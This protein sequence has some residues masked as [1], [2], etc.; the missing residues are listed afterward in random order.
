MDSISNEAPLDPATARARLDAMRPLIQSLNDTVVLQT[1]NRRIAHAFVFGNQSDSAI[2]Y[3]DDALQHARMS[4]D[5]V[6]LVDAC[7]TMGLTLSDLGKTDSAIIIYDE[8]IRIANVMRDS[9]SLGSFY[10]NKAIALSAQG[11]PRLAIRLYLEAVRIQEAL[12]NERNLATCYG[13]IGIEYARLKEYGRSEDF[14]RRA[15]AMNLRV[16][17]RS[18]L[19]RDL[20]NLGVTLKDKGSYQSADSAFQASLAIAREL[21][22][23]MSIAQNLL[24]LG[25]LHTR[26]H[27][28][29]EAEQAFMQSMDICTRNGIRYGVMLNLAGLGSLDVERGR[30]KEG[31]AR[32]Q[33]ALR[34][35][36][37]AALPTEINAIALDLSRAF[38]TAGNHRE[39]Y[40]HLLLWVEG[41]KGV[42]GVT[43]EDMVKRL[44]AELDLEKRENEIEQLRLR[45]TVSELA[46]DRQETYLI[47][48]VIILVLLAILLVVLFLNRRAKVRAFSQLAEKNL[49]IEQASER[50]QDS[51]NLKELLLDVITHDLISPLSTLR[52]AAQ[53]LQEDP[54]NERLVDVIVRSST[55]VG[56]VAINASALSRVAIEDRIPRDWHYVATMIDA[57]LDEAA[58]ELAHSGLTVERNLEPDLQIL[59]NPVLVEV[60]RNYISNAM[61]YASSGKR[62]HIDGFRSGIDVIVRVADFGETIPEEKRTSVFHRRVQLH[63]GS[64]RGSGLGLAIVARIVQAHDGTAWVEPNTPTGNIFCIRIP[65]DPQTS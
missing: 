21:G 32:L 38:A 57:A 12:G 65:S 43:G 60:F 34:M 17:S 54:H 51:N 58:D 52:G 18:D 23:D 5:S 62:L 53:L 3:I 8:G 59:A 31:I 24:N 50:L 2:S 39:A 35:A 64:P 11:N 49:I 42:L 41:Q 14:L 10:A 56:D 6:A 44:E 48:V 22:L 40:R 36:R 7:I 25:N 9:S 27:R 26:M 37:E 30:H 28:Y 29:D 20:V 47:A 46:V 16:G 33:S 45:N 19:G 61:R 13:N 63:A 4:N 55:H 15:V 1:F